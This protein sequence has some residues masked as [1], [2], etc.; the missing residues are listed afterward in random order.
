M[1]RTPVADKSL[2][3]FFFFFFRGQDDRQRTLSAR[4][5]QVL[6]VP[7]LTHL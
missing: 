7:T 4:Q 2:F 6:N 1:Q 5:R 3:F